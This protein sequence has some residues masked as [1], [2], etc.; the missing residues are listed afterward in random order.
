MAER[1][2]HLVLPFIP[3]EFPPKK[4]EFRIGYKKKERYLFSWDNVPGIDS[5]KLSK[6]LKDYHDISWAESEEFDK[7][8]DGKTIRIFKD[9]HSSAEITV[10]EAEENATLKISDGGIHN[11]TVK[12]ENG[13]LNIYKERDKDEFY[14][15]EM[16][17]FNELQRKHKARKRKYEKYL[18]PNLIFKIGI[19]QT[20]SEDA[21]RAELGRMGVKV[22]SPSPGKKGYWVVFAEDEDL[23]EFE[24]KLKDHAQNDRYS[25]FNAVDGIFDIPPNEKIGDYLQEEPFRDDEYSYLTVEIWRMDNIKLGKFL[26]GFE[27]LINSKDGEIVDELTTKNFCLLRIGVGKQLYEDILSLRE[28]A[29]V[30]RPPRTKLEI[31]LN[32]DIGELPIEGNPPD[33]ATGILVVDSGI[34]PGHPLLG[35]AVGDA[36]AVATRYSTKILEDRPYDDVGHGTQVAGVAL[37]GDVHKCI[38]DKSFNP[39]I[40]VF[41]A[42][43]MFKDEDGYAAYDEKELL[44]HQLDGAVRRIVKDY[45]NCRVIN[46]SLGNYDDKMRMYKEKPQ[47][48]LAAHVDE[49][50]KELNVIFVVSAGN[51]DYPDGDYPAYL[52]DETT[53]QAKIIDPATSALALTVG[54]LSR[55]PTREVLSGY[56]K[57][58]PSPI[59]RVGPGYKGMIKPELVEHG[60]GFGEESNVITLNPNWIGEG[61]LFTLVSGTS[62]SAPKV[63][64]YIAR[65]I[66]EYPQKS[67]NLIKALLISSASTPPKS[68][69]PEPLSEIDIYESDKKGMDILKIYGYG[70]PNLEKAIYSEGNRVLLI[71]ENVIKLKQIHFY[72]FYLPKEF[73]ETTGDKQISVTLV[74]DPPINKNRVD[75][76]GAAMETHLFKNIAAEDVIKAYSAVPTDTEEEEIVPKKIKRN[77]IKLHPGFNLRKK[78]VHQK[79]IKKYKMRP[80]IDGDYPLVLVVICQNRWIEDENYLQDYA[81]L[82]TI[83]HSERIDLYNKIRL[84]NKER[85][86]ISFKV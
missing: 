10:D 29:H 5:D 81:V 41:S 85:V 30:N 72:P 57:D 68:K 69:R 34:L 54:A 28:V 83:E 20:V 36:F 23:K 26:K 8:D 43:V 11:L 50:S 47:F 22:I 35:D 6:Y 71:R 18:D 3:K 40:W 45:P 74:F 42:K 16:Q 49:L 37:Y 24:R 14:K 38:D 7:S 4:R 84:R 53:D 66:N 86:E 9:E 51:N 15:T 55:Y 25:F 59:T 61:R 77:E 70:K 56:Q 44:E 65:L 63:S 73:I 1:Y 17:T 79:G 2:E 19:N 78:G 60:G 52:L 64:N 31:A 32:S 76:L 33:D 12:K 62:F 39:E 80:G 27:K 75:Y 46:L 48:N 67:H 58:Y 82:V 21:F 13:K